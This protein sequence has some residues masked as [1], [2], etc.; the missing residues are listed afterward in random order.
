MSNYTPEETLF[1]VIKSEVTRNDGISILELS[2]II[3]KKIKKKKNIRDIMKNIFGQKIHFLSKI[4]LK[5]LNST[6]K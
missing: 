5:L 3:Q 4:F 2:E 6:M 1:R